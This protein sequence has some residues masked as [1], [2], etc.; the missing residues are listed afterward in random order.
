MI[1][2]FKVY[3]SDNAPVEVSKTLKSGYI[4]Q[5]PKVDKFEGMLR[6]RFDHDYVVST[7]SA[8]SAEHLIWH[9]LKTRYGWGD[10]TEILVP[11]VTCSATNWPVVLNGLKIK[12]VD[13]D[14]SNLN[15]DLVDLKRK[16][17]PNTRAILV[18]HW[19]GYPVDLDELKKIRDEAVGVYRQPID[20]VED[21][22][23]AF[24]SSYKGKPIGTHGNY[25]TFSFQA[26]KH[27]TSGDGGALVVNDQFTYNR[28]KLLRWYGLDRETGDREFRCRQDVLEAG[29]KFH[30]NDINAVI[31][32]ENLKEVD[33]NVISVHKDNAAYYRKELSGID[34][35]TLLED[36][37]DRDS[38]YW[39]FTIMVDRKDDFMQK[40]KDKGIMVSRVH[41]R[42]DKHSCVKEYRS[43]LPNVDYVVNHMISIPVGWW[44]TK[45]D[46][47]YIVKSIKEGW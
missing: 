46:R 12:W 15:V 37:N 28:A 18:V 47:E 33:D 16:I 20:I 22:A 13:I 2:L 29:F 38:S 45:E 35:V 14:P 21:C 31:G 36:K 25:C 26:I 24:G 9:M 1:P 6:E 27:L 42:N 4:G 19:G 10:N 7:N 44:V 39:L 40:M 8:T 11:A 34:G 30:M 5:G 32:I 3:M 41:E 43:L 17:G 23:H